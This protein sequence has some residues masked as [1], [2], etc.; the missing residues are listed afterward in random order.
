[1]TKFSKCGVSS[2]LRRWGDMRA[3]SST[4]MCWTGQQG[5]SL[6]VRGGT[7]NCQTG[8]PGTEWLTTDERRLVRK[9][10]F[11]SCTFVSFVIQDSILRAKAFRHNG[12][13]SAL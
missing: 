4:D 11:P 3:S 13:R 6:K 1:M 8:R 9:V 5:R 12:R 7:G 2:D 10:T